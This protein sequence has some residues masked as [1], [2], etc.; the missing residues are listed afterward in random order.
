MTTLAKGVDS[1]ITIDSTVVG[2]IETMS[3]SFSNNSEELK[4]FQEDGSTF[5]KTGETVTISATGK[6][7]STAGDTGQN[8]II[9]AAMTSDA[10]LSGVKF[11]EEDSGYW[12]EAD[13]SEN[14][15]SVFMVDSISIGST[16]G[17]FTEFSAEF[18]CSGDAKRVN[19]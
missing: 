2:K 16:A 11:Y 1:K 7:V 12:W 3:V 18:K 19:S 8:A 5:T 14:A 9:T 10:T 17:S 4:F 13:T 6:L 15:D